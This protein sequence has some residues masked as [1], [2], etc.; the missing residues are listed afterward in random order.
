MHIYKYILYKIAIK[1]LRV[2]WLKGFEIDFSV[3]SQSDMRL[4]TISVR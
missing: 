1:S 4:A 2:D 3:H